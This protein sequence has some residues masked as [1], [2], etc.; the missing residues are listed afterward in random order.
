MNLRRALPSPPSLHRGKRVGI[1]LAERLLLF[2]LKFDHAALVVRITERR[3]DF[4]A[5]AKIRVVHVRVLGGLRQAERDTTKYLCCHK[6]QC[7]NYRGWA[8]RDQQFSR[9]PDQARCTGARPILATYKTRR[10]TYK[11]AIYNFL[12]F[13]S[14]STRDH[15]CTKPGN[16]VSA[17]L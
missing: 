10:G 17:I 3:K 13:R 5:D 11:L 15:C 6:V 12:P 16:G 4:P 7:S 2:G 14:L 9:A 1:I 8:S